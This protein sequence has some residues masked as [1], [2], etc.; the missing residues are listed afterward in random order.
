MVVPMAYGDPFRG[1]PGTLAIFPG[2][3]PLVAEV[4]SA[5]TGNYDVDTKIPVYMQR[6]DLEIWRIHPYDRTLTSWVRQA[7]GTYQETVY[8]G[9]VVGLAALPGVTIDLDRLFTV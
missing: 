5:S 9:G 7:D 8:R 4:W 6:G 1:K 2:P 3:L